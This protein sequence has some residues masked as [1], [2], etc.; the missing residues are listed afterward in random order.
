MPDPRT[1]DRQRHCSKPECKV[2]SKRWRQQRWIR[3]KANRDYFRGSA[4]T[5][6]V[7]AWRKANPDYAKKRRLKKKTLQDDC[8]AQDVHHKRDTP[9]LA[10]RALQDDLQSQRALIVGIV[11]S[12]AGSALQDDIDPLIRMYQTRGQCVLGIGPGIDNQGVCHEQ[13]TTHLSRTGTPGAAE[14]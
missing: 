6:R 9:I 11:S 8:A 13:E 4:H 7:Q 3:K 5:V 1:R 14:V 2:A 10:A 12:L